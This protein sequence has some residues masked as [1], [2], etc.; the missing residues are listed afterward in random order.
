MSGE[1]ETLTPFGRQTNR[2]YYLGGLLF[3]GTLIGLSVWLTPDGR[4]YGTHTQLGLPACSFQ[5][6]TGIPG[7][8]CGMT[9][10]FSHMSSGNLLQ[11]VRA[12]FFGVL[13]YG[14]VLISGLEAL[15]QLLSVD[16]SPI[17]ALAQHVKL[18]HLF[19]VMTLWLLS[20]IFKLYVFA[21]L[22]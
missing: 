19:V 4:G 20:W 9:T 18:R 14:L 6:T 13:M 2:Y 22:I 3:C 10:S 5:K 15:L 17:T 11:A 7:P 1:R 8:S 21:G 12:N 16:F